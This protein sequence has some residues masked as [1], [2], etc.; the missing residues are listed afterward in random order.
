MKNKKKGMSITGK[1]R[2]AG[3]IYLAPATILIFIMSFWPIIQAVITSFKTGSSANMQ[4][5]NPFAYNY[6]RMFQ[7][8][9]FKRSIGNTFL[10]LII[11]VPIMLVLAI[12]LAQLLNNKHL[13]F[14]GFF[15][16][17]VFLPCATSLVSYA[18]IFK[19]LFATQGLINTILVKLGILESNFN[20]LGTGWSA[21]IIIIVALIWRWTGYNMVFFLA[22]LQNIEYS[23]YEAAKIDGASG[24]RTFWSITVPLLRPT[25]VMTTIMSINGTLQLFDESVNLTKGGPANATITMSHY[26]YNG[27][28]GEGVANFGYASAMSVIVFI[29]VAILAFINL[30]VGDKRD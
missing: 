18:L 23:V 14:K 16:T 25:I 8:A 28:F 21:K 4:W 30:K 27:S 13:K 17:C 10:Y 11:E 26:I 29:M 15:R 9:V 1:Q 2:A 22:G 3:W 7:D 5:A 6:T 20:F 24:W 19:S 12:L